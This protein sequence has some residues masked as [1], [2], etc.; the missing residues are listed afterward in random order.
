VA[1]L[2]T[3]GPSGQP[4]IVPIVFAVSPAG[5]RVWT[6]I[7]WK[8]KSPR[9]LRRLDNVRANPAV[10]VLVDAYD[11]A[12]WSAL[13]WARADGR[14]RVVE[15]DEAGDAIAALVAR[16]PQYAREPPAGPV[17]E[18]AVERWTGWSGAR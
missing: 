14:A 13:W 9:G 5:D 17:I 11:D 3:A 6:A 12:D 15:A 2:A 4:H 10:A 1:R 16:Y 18:V 8:P 7:D